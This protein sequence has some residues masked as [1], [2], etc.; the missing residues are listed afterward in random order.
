MLQRAHVVQA[1]GEFDQD[2]SDVVDHR[3]HHLA[4]ILGLLLL[5]GGEI[6]SADFGDA[7]DDMRYLFSE[8]LANVDDG[9]RGVFDGIVQQ[10]RGYGNGIHAH[11]GQHAS[12]F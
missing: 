5:A 9:D 4:K 1:I 8:L 2:D 7:L 11:V 10:A 12:D 3:Q 6:Y